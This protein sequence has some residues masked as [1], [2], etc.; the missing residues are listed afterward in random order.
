MTASAMVLG[1]RLE[2]STASTPREPLDPPSQGPLEIPRGQWN[3]P[4]SR[5]NSPGGRWN[6]PEA[7][8]TSLRPL[9]LLR[10]H[11]NSPGA[12]GTPLGAAGTPPGAAGIPRDRWN[13]PGGR[14]NHN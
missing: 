11:G 13:S 14:W 1:G 2:K 4:G 3:C 8:V 6:S 12:A 9:K 7:A 5:W 10:E